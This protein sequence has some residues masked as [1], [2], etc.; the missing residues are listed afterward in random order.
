MQRDFL[1]ELAEAPVPPV[2]VS[3]NRALHERLNRRLVAGQMLDLALHGMGYT[4]AHFTRAMGGLILL[5]VSGKFER[6]KE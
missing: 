2:P 1:E 4:I 6:Q 5:T 3:F